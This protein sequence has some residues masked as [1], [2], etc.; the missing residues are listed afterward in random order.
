MTILSD[1]SFSYA[2]ELQI[3]EKEMDSDNELED[4][5]DSEA[6]MFG[7]ILPGEVVTGELLESYAHVFH[8][9]FS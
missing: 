8:Q 2:L 3:A 4:L 7:Y 6:S 9:L 1:F 5:D